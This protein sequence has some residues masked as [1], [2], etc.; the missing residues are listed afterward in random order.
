LKGGIS[1][2]PG[3]TLI[4][5]ARYLS[6]VATILVAA[7]VTIDRR[8]AEWALFGLAG[9]TALMGAILVAQ[10][11]VGLSAIAD[12]FGSRARGLLVGGSSL[13]VIVGAAA[14]TR[15]FERHETRRIKAGASLTKFGLDFGASLAVLAIC[16][17]GLVFG[18]APQEIFIA[19]CGLAIM[20]LVVVA[21]RLGLGAWASAILA[22]FAVVMAL[23]LAAARPIGNEDFT[24]RYA[25]ATAPVISLAA[26]VMS[27]TVWTGSG[28]GNYTAL[29]PLYRNA[30]DVS[31]GQTA[32]TSAAQ[33]AIELGPPALWLIL[34]M[35]IALT[36]SLLRGAV[37]RGRDSFYPAAAMSSAVVL[38]LQAFCNAS[39]LSTAIALVA[40]VILGLGLAQSVSRS[41]SP[42]TR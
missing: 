24:L 41:A 10:S 26:R 16:C 30:D 40:A 20:V 23:A 37:Q 2:D 14:A 32:P 7:A 22:A 11:L 15:A 33:I 1:I 9:V 6:V 4:A 21:R 3:A 42:Q 36:G 28:A 13:G 17:L 35:T 38:T 8:R 34:V 5:L 12:G 31:A 29:L 25:N 39:V 27:D 19:A 18:A